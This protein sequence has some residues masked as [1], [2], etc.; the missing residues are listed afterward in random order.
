MTDRSTQR[1]ARLVLADG[2]IF[3]GIAFGATATRGGEVV[4][5]TAHSGYQEVITDPSYTGQ[6]VCMTNPLQGNYGVNPEDDEGAQPFVEGFVVRELAAAP[7]NYRARDALCAWLKKWNVPGISGIDTRAL[8]L[9][10]RASGAINGVLSTEDH[11]DATLLKMARELPSMSGQDLV[12]RVAT[13]KP[14]AWTEGQPD[15]FEMLA[16]DAVDKHVVAIDCGLKRNILRNLA[17]IAKR[18][19]AVPPTTSPEAIRALKPDGLFISNGPGDPAAV[20]Y[21]QETIRALS[22][23]LPI[24]GICLGHQLLGLALGAKTFKLKFGHHGYNHPVKNLLSGRVEITSQNHG[25]AI[26]PATLEGA[27][28]EA[29]HV[30]LYDGTNEGF[31]HRELPLFAV[32]YHPEAAPGP[33]D[34]AYLFDV[35]REVLLTKR[36]PTAEQMAAAQEKL[37]QTAN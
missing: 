15:G 33:H 17:T 2:S 7:S 35:F 18:V 6:I 3:R 20:T 19:T 11:D 16:G 9:R 32:Q 4:F 21:V 24:F 30:N 5:N 8:T 34:A 28:L 26:D 36:P 22:P 27:G 23:E 31:R 12:P 25:F 10:L 37:A 29:T 14:Y 1:P 13:K